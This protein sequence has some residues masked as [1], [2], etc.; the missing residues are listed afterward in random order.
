[1]CILKAAKKAL[2]AMHDYTIS[3]DPS[4]DLQRFMPSGYSKVGVPTKMNFNFIVNIRVF[5]NFSHRYDFYLIFKSEVGLRGFS[6][7]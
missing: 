7:A 6:A 3:V 4:I 2:D 5:S 1:M